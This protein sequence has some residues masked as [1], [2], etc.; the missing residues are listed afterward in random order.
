MRYPFI[1][2]VLL[3]YLSSCGYSALDLEREG[4]DFFHNQNYEEAI[5]KYTE[6]LIEDSSLFKSRFNRGICYYA[7]SDYQKAAN[8]FKSATYLKPTDSL[9]ISLCYFNL[10]LSQ[11]ALD[12]A[13]KALSAFDEAKKLKLSSHNVILQRANCFFKMAD[14]N[15]ASMLYTQALPYFSDSMSIYKSRGIS[16][17]QTNRM[18]AAFIDFETY[19]NKN[20]SPSIIYEFAGIAATS[21]GDYDKAIYYFDQLIESKSSLTGDGEEHMINAL[22]NQSKIEYVQG[23]IN[24]CIE[25]LGKAI[26]INPRA[27]SAYLQRGK[28]FLSLDKYF[29]A[30][31]DLNTAFINGMTEAEALL[32]ESCPEYY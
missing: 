3:Y 13:D 26:T 21:I 6:A 29:E 11:L 30:C 16:Y 10:G 15:K 31:E 12:N 27:K 17:Y 19:L 20:S 28:V 4:N 32:K 14:Y 25:L 7:I 8:D 9:D 18:M 1:V 5:T 24:R 23:D 2:F 22:V